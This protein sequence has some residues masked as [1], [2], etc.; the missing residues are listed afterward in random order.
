MWK[1]GDGSFGLLWILAANQ[2]IQPR[3]CCPCRNSQVMA[4]GMQ[5]VLDAS[6][7]DA[8]LLPG[9][10]AYWVSGILSLKQL[11][12]STTLACWNSYRRLGLLPMYIFPCTWFDYLVW[13]YIWQCCFKYIVAISATLERLQCVTATDPIVSM[14][15]L[16]CKKA[17]FNVLLSVAAG[18]L[19]DTNCPMKI[20][21]WF[22]LRRVVNQVIVLFVQPIIALL[23]ISSCR[24]LLW[25][26]CKS[27]FKTQSLKF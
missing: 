13:K 22:N 6:K 18:S 1:W 19:G 3:P 7:E 9:P 27:L 17:M 5:Y 16:V 11:L 24:K 14:L 21:L 15:T 26:I 2:S 12:G 10:N 25:W 20:E 4:R 8:V 23:I